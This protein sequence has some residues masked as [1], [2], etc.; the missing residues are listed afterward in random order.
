MCVGKWP[1]KALP[2]CIRI[3]RGNAKRCRPTATLFS[4]G[5]FFPNSGRCRFRSGQTR[6]FEAASADEAARLALD[7]RAGR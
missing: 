4:F 7:A 2:H 1:Q 6:C 5:Y 3:S